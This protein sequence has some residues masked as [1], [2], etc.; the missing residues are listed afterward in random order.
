MPYKEKVAWLSL[1]AMALTFGPYFTLV[2]SAPPSN[3][4]LPDLRQ[5]G[6]YAV[7]AIAQ[8]CILGI[9][10]LVLRH[11]SP[12]EARLPPDERDRAIKHRAISMAY[13]VLMS[14]VVLVGVVMPFVFNGWA[15][16]NAALATIIAGEVVHYGVVVACYRRQA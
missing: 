5:L 13:Y 10:H 4:A 14:G 3:S 2:A 11:M 9:G 8:M 15:I 12:L 6:L 16:V 7:T 1:L